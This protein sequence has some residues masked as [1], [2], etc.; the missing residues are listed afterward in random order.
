M[1]NHSRLVN[2]AAANKQRNIRATKADIVRNILY[3]FIF[4]RE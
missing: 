1:I 3:E 4:C 2:K